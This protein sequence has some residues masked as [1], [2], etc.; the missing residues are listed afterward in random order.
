[1]RKYLPRIYKWGQKKAYRFIFLAQWTLEGQLQTDQ[2][3]A[4]IEWWS[5]HRKFLTKVKGSRWKFEFY[6]L[7][8]FKDRLVIMYVLSSQIV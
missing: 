5:H 3:I 7:A 8:N 1:M 4:R 2:F 6:H